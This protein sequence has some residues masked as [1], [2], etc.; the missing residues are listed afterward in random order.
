MGDL[1]LEEI[2]SCLENLKIYE[3]K[4]TSFQFE[5]LSLR[6]LEL[7]HYISTDS[8][9]RIAYSFGK[10]DAGTDELWDSL[11]NLFLFRLTDVN[12]K[13]LLK[14]VKGFAGANRGSD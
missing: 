9:V 10:F 1:S 4:V 6:I 5:I 8:L 2:L 14:A 3:K 11:A 13:D 12:K 7:T